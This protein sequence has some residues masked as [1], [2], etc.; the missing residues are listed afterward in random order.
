MRRDMVSA[1]LLPSPF[2]LAGRLMRECVRCRIVPAA[3]VP[4][5]WDF[6]APPL[7]PPA[8]DSDTAAPT[9]DKGVHVPSADDTDVGAPPTDGPAS[10]DSKATPAPDD[11][12]APAPFPAQAPA[13]GALPEPAPERVPSPS[14]PAALAPPSDALTPPPPSEPLNPPELLPMSLAALVVSADK[15]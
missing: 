15:A 12:A 7:P 5:P 13:P 1:P 6:P 2:L 8:A 9:D 4:R 14:L 3:L 10:D 11:D